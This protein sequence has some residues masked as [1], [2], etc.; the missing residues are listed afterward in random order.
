MEELRLAL[1]EW[2][3]PYNSSWLIERHGFLSGE[4]TTSSGWIATA[5]GAHWLLLYSRSRGLGA[6]VVAITFAQIRLTQGTLSGE[7]AWGPR[8]APADLS[9][10]SYQLLKVLCSRNEMAGTIAPRIF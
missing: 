10:R 7:R 9:N 1:L 2:A 4:E 3:A 5:G 6:V 8:L